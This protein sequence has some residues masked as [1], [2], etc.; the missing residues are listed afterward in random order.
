[1]L[2]DFNLQEGEDD[3]SPPFIHALASCLRDEEDL[4]ATVP[5]PVVIEEVSNWIRFAGEESWDRGENRKS[6]V[7][8]L[9]LANLAVG[10]LLRRVLSPELHAYKLGI[11][12]PIAADKKARPEARTEALARGTELIGKLCSPKAITA[13]WNDLIGL[14]RQGTADSRDL[15]SIVD[16]L[17]AQLDVAGHDAKV[18]LRRIVQ[19]LLQM[20]HERTD[21]TSSEDGTLERHLKEPLDVADRLQASD[22]L[23]SKLP[24]TGSCVVWLG[25]R[26]GRVDNPVPAGDV[27]FLDA[28][29]SIPNAAL[30]DGQD[31]EYRDELSLLTKAGVYK[32]TYE[33][34]TIAPEVGLLVRVDLGRR[35]ARGAKEDA[36]AIADA[37]LDLVIW[38]SGGLRPIGDHATLILDGRGRSSWS[39]SSVRGPDSA[40]YRGMNITSD[41]I[42]DF[43]PDIGEA[44]AKRTMPDL[45]I[46]AVRASTESDSTRSRE[47]LLGLPG[48]AQ[49]RTVVVL[50]DQIVDYIAMHA[51]VER[52]ILESATK[53][54]W[55]HERWWAEVNR[56]AQIC[57]YGG[58]GPQRS[59]EVE[60]LRREMFHSTSERSLLAS[61]VRHEA[62]LIRLCPVESERSYVTT[63]LRS[64]TSAQGYL[65]LRSNYDKDWDTLTSR[66]HRVRN[67]IAHGN[68]VRTEMLESVLEI[69]RYVSSDALGVALRAF[70]DNTEVVT[71]L[72]E[73]EVNAI[74]RNE[75]LLQGTSIVDI[76]LDG[77]D[78][79]SNDLKL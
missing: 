52:K 59:A 79:E 65:S 19:V 11:S 13:T 31:F 25:Y 72:K 64:I 6:L 54:E 39:W 68:P 27:T 42:R 57:L 18:L 60:N 17:R 2:S 26:H 73:R 36:I 78:A 58:G 56:A 32:Y 8:D 34:G 69:S 47:A 30:D 74:R 51:R 24:E 77:L 71:L 45:L 14:A 21:I 40:D 44:W 61:L 12:N 66:W 48:K 41:A 63:R 10:T 37:L 29:W 9:D 50:Q 4:I 70:T 46:E 3:H 7:R 43:A 53:Q 35:V 75:A 67:G 28:G 16:L 62:D 5:L 76:L 15:R 23:L 22:G 1:M 33:T 38:R 20:E 55:M 49:D